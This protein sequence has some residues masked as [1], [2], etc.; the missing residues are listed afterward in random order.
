M[1]LAA[2]IAGLAIG[3]GAAWLTRSS[4]GGSQSTPAQL[5]VGDSRPEF[6]HAGIYGQLWRTS[7]FDGKPLLVNFWATWCAP[8]VREMPL[9]QE[10]AEENVN[11]LQ[12]I[13]VAIDEPG[14][15]RGFIEG[16]G[17]DYP[18]L[19]GT[20]DVRATLQAYGNRGGMLPYTALVD[21]GGIVRWLHLGELK[22]DEV[23]R[24]VTAVL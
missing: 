16:L 1:L 8:C 4:D 14:A 17:I 7:D 15:V 10:I 13:G 6:E 19:I 12:V 9:L 23:R 22:P 20:S 5:K 18:I 2:S 21:A 3:I 11:S 24:Q